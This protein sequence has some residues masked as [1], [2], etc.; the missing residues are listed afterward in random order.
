MVQEGKDYGARDLEEMYGF[1]KK[2]RHF[3][4]GNGS[5]RVVIVEAGMAVMSM[6]M[7][8]NRSLLF[9]VKRGLRM[10][11]GCRWILWRVPRLAAR[12]RRSIS[13]TT[14]R[15]RELARNSDKGEDAMADVEAET[16]IL[17]VLR[18]GTVNE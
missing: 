11:A 16:F 15:R 10:M 14:R 9:R 13:R 2:K 3:F 5:M 4:P 8:I 1:I 12:P 18:W 6:N 17:V 7:S